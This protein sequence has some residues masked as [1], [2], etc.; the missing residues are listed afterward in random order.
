MT[1]QHPEY[2]V[3]SLKDDVLH[4]DQFAKRLVRTL[5]SEKTR[6]ATANVVGLAGS[7]GAGKSSLL[8][9][10][11]EQ[12][13]TEYPKAIVV[14]FNPWLVSGRNDLVGEFLGELL[15]MISRSKGKIAQSEVLMKVLVEYGTRL[16][17]VLDLV[18]YGA[19]AQGVVKAAASFLERGESLAGLRK[20]LLHELTTFPEPIV[21]LIDEVDRVEDAEIHALAQLVRSIADFPNVS[22]L[23][24]YDA[25][26]V[27]E[28]LGNGSAER[29]RSYLEKII[30]LQIPVPAL[31]PQEM[32]AVLRTELTHIADFNMPQGFLADQ[33]YQQ[34]E[35]MLVLRVLPTLRDIKRLIGTF[36]AVYALV[37]GE[38]DWI[39]VLGYCALLAKAPMTAEKLKKYADI[40]ADNPFANELSR[41]N[42][43][44]YPP[45]SV[46]SDMI[47]TSEDGP[48]VRALLAALFPKLRGVRRN[49]APYVEPLSSRYSLNAV[50]RLGAATDATWSRA[51]VTAL[52]RKQPAEIAQELR[53]LE[54]SGK[55]LDFN[56]RVRDLYADLEG[57]QP[58]HF[59]RGVSLFL[60]PD[61]PTWDKR[62]LGKVQQIDS[63]AD[64]LMRWAGAPG[65][66]DILTSTFESLAQAGD[67]TI[68][69]QLLRQ[70]AASHGLDGD[71]PRGEAGWFLTREQT[72]TAIKTSAVAW[73]ALQLED[74][75]L[76]RLWEVSALFVMLTAGA[77]DAECIKQL[78]ETVRTRIEAFDAMM[79][80]LFGPE[81]D[82]NPGVAAG[83]KLLVDEEVVRP[84]TIERRQWVRPDAQ[85]H[86]ADQ[87]HAS[88]IVGID[89][90]RSAFGA[91]T[92]NP[93]PKLSSWVNLIPAPTPQQ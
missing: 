86:G 14:R 36:R 88:V 43:R 44:Y 90:A 22:Y 81:Y 63:Y 57:F 42:P 64:I 12:I 38:A 84:L 41:R 15:A 87:E 69:S 13:L 11:E 24:A 79:L 37:R 56:N 50:L 75:L 67:I 26:R 16:S 10:V 92:A 1:A 76:P 60:E 31:I 7:W 52:S 17:P 71:K 5:I 30:Q 23:L 20:R 70:H 61:P 32:T 83:A 65:M 54:K 33:R 53:S 74:K 45:D 78:T 66:R 55:L 49:A 93:G 73:R 21:A 48:G 47:A 19:A 18:P 68:V 29:G 27:A 58:D 91:S 40:L 77:W 82:Y 2:A 46:L 25:T 39:D 8:N 6:K 85:K 59:W 51:E 89:N 72:L 28:A 9:F 80:M 34:M 4:R 62:Y 35:E 3:Q